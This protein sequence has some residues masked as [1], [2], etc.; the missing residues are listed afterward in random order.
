M[1][2]T[3]TSVTNVTIDLDADGNGSYETTV[4]K[5]WSEIL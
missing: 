1:R 5:R 4:N 2:V 3:A